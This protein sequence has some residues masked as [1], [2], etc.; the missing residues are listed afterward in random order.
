[1]FQEP[2]PEAPVPFGAY[3]L[4]RRIGAGGMGEVFLARE[5]KNGETRACVVKKVLPSLQANRAFVGRFLDESKVVVRLSHSNV[6]RVYAMGEADGEYF[7]TM[8]YVQGKTVSRFTKRLRDRKTQMP[9]GAI[10]LIG[11]RVCTGLQYAHD[12]TDE[13][14]QPLQ[15]VHR[16]LSPANV[17]I[18]Y[19]GEVKIID[20]GA[21][22][23]TLK[24]EQTAPRVVIGNLTYMAPEQAKKQ[25]V[26]RRADVYS[27]GVML[28][29]LLSWFAL[30]QKGDPIE[31][32][33]KAANPHWD[34]PSVHN[35]NVP[36][37]LD[38]LVLRALRKDPDARFKSAAELGAALREMR[39]RLS[40][41][42]GEA[43]LGALLSKAFAREKTA[44]D[45]VLAETLGKPVI[46]EVPTDKKRRTN[47]IPVTA[48]AFEHNAVLAEDVPSEEELTDPGRVTLGDDPPA[49][50]PRKEPI[51]LTKK[52][53]RPQE[54]VA[55][56]STGEMG[57]V[58]TRRAFG[59]QFEAQDPLIERSLVM[60]IEGGSDEEEEPEYLTHPYA[61]RSGS[62]IV[63]AIGVFLAAVGLGFLGVW[64][65]ANHQP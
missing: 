43:E 9:L 31:R 17:C 34:A 58:S 8:E 56:L 35:P 32:W 46:D 19:R 42:Y 64:L 59:V 15:L 23:S 27:T 26:D 38:A 65:W 48:L 24:E 25:F 50:T 63:V 52:K 6:A 28:W 2:S 44:E 39:Q 22:Q 14:G 36:P 4:I 12:A 21:A 57:A 1:M 40:P 61:N 10:L 3:E 51:E 49:P 47:V 11:E 55:T 54:K 37:E 18:S 5:K 45:A 60:E 30:P 29:E 13:R 7:L 53:T 41:N 62:F 20:F 33:R 16:D